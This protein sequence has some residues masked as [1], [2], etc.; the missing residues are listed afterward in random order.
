MKKSRKMKAV[1]TLKSGKSI[2]VS[3]PED[4]CFYIYNQWVQFLSPTKTENS[5]DIAVDI[6]V[7]NMSK[8]RENLIVEMVGILLSDISAIQIVDY[9]NKLNDDPLV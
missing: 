1:F 6:A 8:K 5:N 3:M 7:V 4:Q 9:D 2:V